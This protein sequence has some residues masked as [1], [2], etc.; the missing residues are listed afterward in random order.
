MRKCIDEMRKKKMKG[1]KGRDGQ[2]EEEKIE[3]ARWQTRSKKKEKKDGEQRG[4]K[5]HPSVYTKRT[6]FCLSSL[7]ATSCPPDS[8]ARGNKRRERKTN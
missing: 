8:E 7:T 2:R 6:N 1:A 3:I 5:C 4:R